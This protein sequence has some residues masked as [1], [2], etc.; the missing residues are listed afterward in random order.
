MVKVRHAISDTTG[1]PLNPVKFVVESVI[2]RATGVA[3]LHCGATDFLIH[4]NG[5]G[6]RDP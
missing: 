3:M 1:L 6:A 5:S 2:T 4:V